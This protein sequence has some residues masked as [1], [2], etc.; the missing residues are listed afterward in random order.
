MLAKR[1]F[2]VFVWPS[3][4]AV[5]F[6][7]RRSRPCAH[8]SKVILNRTGALGQNLCFSCTETTRQRSL[9]HT[10]FDVLTEPGVLLFQETV[11]IR[12]CDATLTTSR[13]VTSCYKRSTNR[14]FHHV[15]T[16]RDHL[17]CLKLVAFSRSRNK[18]EKDSS[19]KMTSCETRALDQCDN[20]FLGC[21]AASKI[22]PNHPCVT[23]TPGQ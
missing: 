4:F 12:G 21:A 18:A 22:Y 16:C 2:A 11:V 9:F 15:Q 13:H 19:R 5:V 10:N 7:V 6:C 20:V 23:R 1:F 8:I 3:L 17:L 14:Q